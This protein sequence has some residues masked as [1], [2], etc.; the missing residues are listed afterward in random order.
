MIDKKLVHAILM[1]LAK[2]YGNYT[3]Y[4][5]IQVEG[6]ESKQVQGYIAVMNDGG[7]IS[8]RGGDGIPGSSPMQIRI[9]WKGYEWLEK[10]PV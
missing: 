6:Y 9:C 1:V 7:L 2:E 10:N 5:S 3:S 8:F 4:D